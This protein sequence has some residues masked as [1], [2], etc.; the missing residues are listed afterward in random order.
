MMEA[1]TAYAETEEEW[2]QEEEY[3]ATAAS[4]DA[5]VTGTVRLPGDWEDKMKEFFPDENLRRMVKEKFESGEAYRGGG[6]TEE[7]LGN[8]KSFTLEVKNLCP[9]DPANVTDFTGIEK[10][11]SKNIPDGGRTPEITVKYISPSVD[12]ST[13]E[14]IPGKVTH[15]VLDH[16]ETPVGVLTS[17][18][19]YDFNQI[20]GNRCNLPSFLSVKNDQELFTNPAELK[21]VRS[22]SNEKTVTVYLGVEKRNSSGTTEGVAGSGLVEFMPSNLPS[23][24]GVME[25]KEINKDKN[26]IK[27]SLKGASTIDYKSGQTY[28]LGYSFNRYDQ[29]KKGTQTTYNSQSYSY[30]YS[31]R[32]VYYSAVNWEIQ[33]QLYSGFKFKKTSS[34]AGGNGT[35]SLSGAKY[36]VSRQKQAVYTEA[37]ANALSRSWLAG[38]PKYETDTDGSVNYSKPIYE[39]D[40]AGQPVYEYLKAEGQKNPYAAAVFTT[41]RDEA[42]VYTT[43][44]DGT[45]TADMIPAGSLQ[46]AAYKDATDNTQGSSVSTRYYVTEVKAPDGYALSNAKPTEI[47]VTG[48]TSGIRLEAE[49]G[50]GDTIKD[51]YEGEVTL[52]ADFIHKGNNHDMEIEGKQPVQQATVFIRNAEDADDAFNEW[53]IPDGKD[54]KYVTVSYTKN[55]T[56]DDRYETLQEPGYKVVDLE[57]NAVP[58]LE[59]I[60][61]VEDLSEKINTVIIDGNLA[62]E[63]KDSYNIVAAQADNQELVYY[64]KEWKTNYQIADEAGDQSVAGVQKNDPLPVSIRFSAN[65][66]LS[67]KTGDLKG[68]DFQFT[69]KPDQTVANDPVAPA[70]ITAVNTADGLIDFGTLLYQTTGTYTYTLKETQDWYQGN[71]YTA[72]DISFDTAEHKVTVKV[73]EKESKKGTTNGLTVTMTVDGRTVSGTDWNSKNHKKPYEIADADKL[74]INNSRKISI[75]GTKTWEDQNNAWN[76]RPDAADPT[77]VVL[78]VLAGGKKVTPQPQVVWNTANDGTGTWTYKIEGLP[79]A[80]AN[81]TIKYTVKE[82][83]VPG[84]QAAYGK[85]TTDAKGNITQDITNSMLKAS[86]KIEKSRLTKATENGKTGTWGFVKGDLVEYQVTVENTGDLELTMDVTDVFTDSTLFKEL[87]ADKAATGTGVK[88][89]GPCAAAVGVGRNVTIE[90]GKKATIT[91]TA[92][93]DTDQVF[94]DDA[95]NRDWTKPDNEGAKGY[96]NTATASHVKARE[97][98]EGGKD[99]IYTKDGSDGTQPYPDNGDGTNE[100]ADKTDVAKTPV[101]PKMGYEIA[102]SRIDAPEK[103]GT[104]PKNTDSSVET[105]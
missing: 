11:A 68:G 80:D 75:T 37:E 57:G 84:Y 72:G 19:L 98:A 5:R 65:K 13:W 33:S 83:K 32:A 100:L 24:P 31:L 50:Y 52:K 43:G 69:L 93:V 53:G 89:N 87:K 12:M 39:K 51:A 91:F 90:P 30:S 79:E 54:V 99:I 25:A 28:K 63:E 78:T 76:R 21:F 49:G 27:L 36:I 4:I 23:V 16:L 105:Q 61:S 97:E 92:I 29:Y 34:L 44:A 64:D 7:V 74:T 22:N 96:V 45:F 85:Q 26:Y 86:Y 73:E 77:K 101:R 59:N 60:A 10:V 14:K 103:P 81:G 56:D 1:L 58:G 40:A 102:K 55:G 20:Y 66:T 47:T 6:T 104:N 62:K 41:D 35:Q 67:G 17:T 82:E 38:M 8:S 42:H 3:E 95:A 94:T 88:D 70:G 46:T 48:N 2:D 71:A 15:V 18:G 9:G